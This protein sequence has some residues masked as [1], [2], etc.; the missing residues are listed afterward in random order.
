M[1]MNLKGSIIVAVGETYGLKKVNINKVAV[2]EAY[3]KNKN[4]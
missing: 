4:D 3:G 2:G 1:M